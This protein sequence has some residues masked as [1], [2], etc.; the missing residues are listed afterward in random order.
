MKCPK[1]KEEMAKVT[2]GFGTYRHSQCCKN[3]ACWF[4][5]IMRLC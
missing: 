1:C 2:D 5:G 3:K 4:F